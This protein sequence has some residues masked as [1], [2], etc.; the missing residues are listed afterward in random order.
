MFA[1]RASQAG[2]LAL[3]CRRPRS[4]DDAV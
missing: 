1:I 2:W 3:P 4:W